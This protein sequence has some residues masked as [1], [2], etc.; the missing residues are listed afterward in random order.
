MKTTRTTQI[1]GLSWVAALG[2]FC[3][4]SLGAEEVKLDLRGDFAW[5]IGKLRPEAS[6]KMEIPD[7][8]G[9]TEG[10]DVDLTSKQKPFSIVAVTL[11]AKKP[12]TFDLI[13]DF[14][15]MRDDLQ[16]RVCRGIRIL[17]PQ[18]DPRAAAFHPPRNAS[19]WPGHSGD[20]ISCKKGDSIVFELLFDHVW[21]YQQAELI[22]A[23]SMAVPREG[24]IE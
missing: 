24:K 21:R 6:V 2:I 18:P 1:R 9:F 17:N 7:C 15:L 5:T 10:K 22:V 8:V 13:P 11:S 3:I 4:P 16:Y 14:F 23:S 12:G 19:V 20:R